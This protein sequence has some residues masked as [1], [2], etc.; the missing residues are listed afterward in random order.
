MGVRHFYAEGLVF[1]YFCFMFYFIGIGD[2]DGDVNYSMGGRMW[3]KWVLFLFFIFCL[4]IFIVLLL[5]FLYFY[6][7]A[8]Y[9]FYVL[10]VCIF[11]IIYAYVCLGI[12]GFFMHLLVKRGRICI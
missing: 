8:V 7:F 11:I 10:C 12:C 3:R 4:F 1:C 6:I 9:F 5:F 2:I